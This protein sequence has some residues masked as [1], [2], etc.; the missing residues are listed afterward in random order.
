VIGKG[1]IVYHR[2][3]RETPMM[4][5][6]VNK[7]LSKDKTT[8]F[9]TLKCRYKDAHGQFHIYEFSP[10]EIIE[11]YLNPELLKES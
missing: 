5:L 6:R 1:T 10:F 11:T 9:I 8:E 4:L 2:L 3:D 7:I